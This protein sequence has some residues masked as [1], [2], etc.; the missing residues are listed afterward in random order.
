[1]PGPTRWR[2]D[3][4]KDLRTSSDDRDVVVGLLN[5]AYAAGR[6]DAE[7]HDMLVDRALRVGTYRELHALVD[8][9]PIDARR[10]PQPPAGGPSR[11]GLAVG[12]AVLVAAAGAGVWWLVSSDTAEPEQVTAAPAASPTP[13]PA[14]P[15]VPTPRASQRPTPGPT[16]AAEPT[17][18]PT[19]LPRLAPEA[20]PAPPGRDGGPFDPTVAPV[21]RSGA[22]TT[23]VTVPW[24]AGVLPMIEFQVDRPDYDLFA[25]ADADGTPFFTYLDADGRGGRVSGATV[26]PAY[27][28]PTEDQLRV[29][30]ETEGSWTVTLRDVDDAPTLGT[31]GSGSG[32]QVGWYDGLEA[33]FSMS[34]DDGNFA[35]WD[36]WRLIVNGV[37]P[38]RDEGVIEAGRRLLRI[39][40]DAPWRY[41]IR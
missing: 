1:M 19:P 38:G 16:P 28:V 29:K 41:E 25:L 5:E 26:M 22:G 15:A 12:A 20:D 35:V 8:G 13:T 10:L 11:G 2:A 30:V 9:L 17:V 36:D 4:E 31:S 40:A 7:E 23:I 21:T 24:A 33:V 14:T 39:E 18:E 27:D 34:A 32:Y 37:G 3:A 6:L